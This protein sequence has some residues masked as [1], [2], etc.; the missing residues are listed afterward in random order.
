MYRVTHYF[1]FVYGVELDGEVL[2][3]VLRSNFL[4]TAR[5]PRPG[6]GPSPRRRRIRAIC[7]IGV[8]SLLDSNPKQ[9]RN[10]SLSLST[11]VIDCLADD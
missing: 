11:S 5:S 6:P 2:Q 1:Q 7:H 4:V 8:C 3:I 9:Y 10:I